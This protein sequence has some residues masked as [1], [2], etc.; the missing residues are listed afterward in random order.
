[1]S[2]LFRQQKSAIVKIYSEKWDTS[3]VQRSAAAPSMINIAVTTG[4]PYANQA[5]FMRRGEGRGSNS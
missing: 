1:M 2:I 4:N 3:S 5:N